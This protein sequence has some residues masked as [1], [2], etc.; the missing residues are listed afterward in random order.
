[1]ERETCLNSEITRVFVEKKPFLAI[2]SQTL[3]KDL[4]ETLRINALESVRI[5]NRYDFFQLNSEDLD[6]AVKNVF[7]EP[8][9]DVVYYENFPVDFNERYFVVEYLPG[10]YD[11]RA[12]WASQCLQILLQNERPLLRTAK[13]I[14]LQGEISDDDFN[15][16][17][18]YCINEVEARETSLDSP[19]SLSLKVAI[20]KDIE[21]IEGFCTMSEADLSSLITSM[22]LAM[23]Y[24]DLLACKE[25]FSQEEN[26]DPTVT[27]LRVLDT[28]WSDHCRHT[29]FLTFL[30]NIAFDDTD[31]FEPLKEAYSDY[32]KTRID[33]SKEF[34][35]ITLMDIATIAAKA[36]KS[37]GVITDIDNS[38]EINAASI[39]AKVDVDGIDEEYLIMFKNETHNH[40]TEIEPF[41]GAATCLGG[42]IRDPLSGRTYVYQAM[43]ITGSGDPTKD[44]ETTLPGKLPQK[45]ITTGA[46]HGFSAYGNQI[47]LATGLVKEIYD[48]GYI[49][50]RMELGAVIAA[51]PKKNVVREKPKAGDVVILLGGKTGRDGCGGATGSSKSHTEDSLAACGA[52]VQ[53]GNAVEERKIQ[54]FFRNDKVTR[55][56]KKCND[57]GAG[58]VSVA[59]GELAE[60]ITIFL[61]LVPKKYDGLDGTEIAISESQERMAIVTA[62]ESAQLFIEEAEKENLEAT[63]VAKITDDKRLKMIWRNKTILDISRKFLDTN[64]A[65]RS[66]DVLIESY[67][68]SKFPLSS[69]QYTTDPI[70]SWLNRLSDLNE[71]SQEGLASRFDSTIGS[72]TVLMPYGGKYQST[73]VNG[74]VAKIPVLQGETRTCTIM[75]CGYDPEIA[76][77]SPFH[78]G[79]FSVVESIANAVAL[80]ADYRTLRLTMQEYF[81]KLNVDPKKWGKVFSAL[82]GAFHV[83]MNFKIPA[84]GG[85]DSM[86]G[87][88]KELNVPPTIVTFA[89]A[90]ADASK[91]ISP[92]F[93]KLDS[94][95]VL[96]PGNLNSEFLPDLTGLE[97]QYSRIHS[98]IIQ[99]KIVSASAVK[100]STVV[101]TI[102]KMSFGNM[103]GIKFEDDID[104]KKLSKPQ[105]GSIL[106]EI[107]DGLNI[108]EMFEGL[109]T[110]KIGRT[111]LDQRFILK[112]FSLNL[113]TAIDSWQSKFEK[114]FPTKINNGDF[115]CD[116]FS[117]RGNTRYSSLVKVAKPK[118]L[119]PVFPGTNC[120]YDILREF[121][122]AGAIPQVIVFKNKVV[123]DVIE[124]LTRL[125]Q[126]ISTSQIICIPGGFSAG[127]EPDGSGKFIS[128]VF[129]N[130]KIKNALNNFLVKQDGLI[131]GIC[132]GFQALIKIGLLPYGQIKDLDEDSPT[133]TFNKIGRHMS[134]MVKTRVASNKSPWLQNCSP[135]DIH[136]V[137]VSHGEGRFIANKDHLNKLSQSGQIAF[138]YVDE[139]DEP[140]YKMPWNPNGSIQAIEGIVSPDGR[141]LGK[142][143]H[144]ERIGEHTLKNVPGNRDQGLFESGVNYFK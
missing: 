15:R 126:E 137:P 92:E 98:L 63:I 50:K 38:D 136:V 46:A 29:T 127:D 20:P 30:K 106:L 6:L 132:N 93:K 129:K 71:A 120:E 118:V 48:E 57:F 99:D 22:N 24:K 33:L 44:V 36:L 23:D 82:L 105:C 85:K 47:G 1:M 73:P 65:Q 103:I 96:I 43:R 11:Q 83:Q 90:L 39:I 112:R 61:D 121:E 12:E 55:L 100:N 9:V 97:K 7:S 81:E 76:N 18:T 8:P 113:S 94:T 78:A 123:S 89:V 142:M 79:V 41:G 35:P 108:D 87:T 125:E 69:F 75:T 10:Q 80:G 74:M 17:K 59:I 2:E 77:W 102:S 86:S 58:G 88:F 56:I 144:S 109:E 54:R 32:I 114:V 26:R 31:S 45:T 104:L 133:L 64:G 111:I 141:I 139:N 34:E 128:I 131:L 135:G 117:F 122:K 42:A 130:P 21:T 14:V 72:G 67:D 138:Q 52:E 4:R 3:L 134:Y 66:N 40:P 68:K 91:I 13:V 37:K 5:L 110:I 60:S 62:E 70:N 25:Y 84:I 53:K 143:A 28:Y 115:P 101:E 49:A 16:I 124:S 51:G 116:T 140:T 19:R 119:I 95:I 107:P 27:E